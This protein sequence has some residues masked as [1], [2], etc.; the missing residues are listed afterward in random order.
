[1]I[2]ARSLSRGK[3]QSVIPIEPRFDGTRLC[4]DPSDLI[5]ENAFLAI[6]KGVQKMLELFRGDYVAASFGEWRK[7]RFGHEA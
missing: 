2:S 6:E 7:G 1:M 5:E 4:V 3:W